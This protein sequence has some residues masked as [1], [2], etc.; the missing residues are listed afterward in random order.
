MNKNVRLRMGNMCFENIQDIYEIVKYEPNGY[1]GK[2]EDYELI[3]VNSFNGNETDA[4]AYTPKGEGY[5]SFIIDKSCFQNPERCYVVASFDVD[6]EGA[7]LVWC[8]ERPLRLT[9]SEWQ[10]FMECVKFG[11]SHIDGVVNNNNIYTFDMSN[12]EISD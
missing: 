11:Y 5:G 12:I 3:K 6:D 2:E 9:K 7:N 10:D 1:Y 4:Y 8:G